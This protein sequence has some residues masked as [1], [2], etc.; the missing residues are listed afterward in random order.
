M[1]KKNSLE[2][3]CLYQSTKLKIGLHREGVGNCYVCE[4]D[5][6]NKNCKN[7]IPIYLS[8]YEVKNGKNNN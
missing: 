5:V 2:T 3:V 1:E 7:Y 6:T 8:Y 4:P